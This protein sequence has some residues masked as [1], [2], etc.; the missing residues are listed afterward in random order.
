[1]RVKV[2][3]LFAL[4]ILMP[5]LS[6]C[7]SDNEEYFNNEEYLDNF[8]VVWQIMN[9]LYYDPT[10]GGLDW[11]EV[12][13]RYRPMIAAAV[14]DDEFYMIINEMLFELNVSHLFVIPPGAEGEIDTM[15]TAEAS[16]GIEVRLLDDD[17]VITYVDHG[18]SAE[19]AGLLPGY[20]IQSINGVSIDEIIKDLPFLLPPYNE[21]TLRSQ[22]IATIQSHFYGKLDT[23]VQ[24]TYLDGQNEVNEVLI[25]LRKRNGS[26]TDL[27]NINLPTFY[28]EVE[29]RLI[30]DNMGYIS[31]NAFIPPADSKFREAIEELGN[32]SGLIIDIRGNSGGIWPIRKTIAEMLVS[33][34]TLSWV[35]HGREN[36]REVYL[37][38]AHYVY[39]GPVVVL[40]DVMSFSSAEEFA[41]AMK[42]IDRA[43]IVGERTSGKVLVLD[44]TQLPNGATFMYPVEESR[45]A[46]GTV[47]EGRGVIPD[48]EVELD[49]ETLL[50]GIDSQLEMAIEYLIQHIVN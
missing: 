17:A 14:N 20:I 32:V 35:Y 36:I 28:V 50:T 29:S 45:T 11:N 42:S 31:F 2:L 49:R 48:M 47:L 1:M 39:E 7:S 9:E 13:D 10:F 22:Q 25:P 40:V 19:Q 44:I 5:G 4:L 24:I 27:S 8:E 21:R 30:E 41:G 15:A 12:R 3:L 18:S 6:A 46:E 23:L 16:A 43:V 38:P 33:E 37:E 26:A 34:R